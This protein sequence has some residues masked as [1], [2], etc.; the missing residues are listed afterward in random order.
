VKRP[1][2]KI[3]MMRA[4]LALLIFTL[5]PLQFSAA[6]AVECCGHLAITQSTQ[7]KHQQQTP[8][9]SATDTDGLAADIAG[10]D[11]DCE[12]CH[13]NCTAAITANSAAM[14][15]PRGSEQIEHLSERHFLLWH[16]RPYRPQWQPREIRG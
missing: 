5:L 4:F 15:S 1:P 14:L 12:T 3:L 10:L 11:L 8:T 16:Q 9:S 6:A 2:H 7:A 13:T